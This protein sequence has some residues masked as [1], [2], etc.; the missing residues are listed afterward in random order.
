[1]ENMEKTSVVMDD[2]RGFKSVCIRLWRENKVAV[3]CAVI[4]LYTQKN[5]YDTPSESR[6]TL[7]P[8]RQ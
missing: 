7:L 3:L 5:P 1:M 6:P 4:I 8:S 2:G